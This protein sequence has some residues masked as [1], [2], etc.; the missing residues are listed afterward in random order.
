VIVFKDAGA[1]APLV[2]EDCGGMAGK[3]VFGRDGERIGVIAAIVDPREEPPG[4]PGSRVFLVEPDPFATGPDDGLF[5]TEPP[6]GGLL[7][8]PAVLADASDGRDALY[9]T[10]A[11]IADVSAEAVTLVCTGEEIDAGGWMAT[12]A[13]LGDASRT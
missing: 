10:E 7:L 9:V 8:R 1:S 11:A 6:F 4:A 12:P 5:M 3:D 2:P 13:G